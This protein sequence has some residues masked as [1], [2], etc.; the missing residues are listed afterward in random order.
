MVS[1]FVKSGV[2]FKLCVNCALYWADEGQDKDCMTPVDPPVLTT[3]IHF[4]LRRSNRQT[5][6]QLCCHSV[7][8]IPRTCKIM[9]WQQDAST[10]T[11]TFTNIF[12][13]FGCRLIFHWQ[14]WGHILLNVFAVL[15]L[16]SQLGCMYQAELTLLGLQQHYTKLKETK[17][18]KSCWTCLAV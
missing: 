8:F 17:N 2:L 18:H 16:L 9:V 4:V 14:E 5:T 3:E 1:P 12:G 7:H 15:L 13:H 6:S 10:L 11:L